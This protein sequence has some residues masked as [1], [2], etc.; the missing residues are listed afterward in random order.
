MSSKNIFADQKKESMLGLRNSS[1]TYHK[2]KKIIGNVYRSYFLIKKYSL[3]ESQVYNNC[4][5]LSMTHA[6]L[7]VC[8]SLA[9][10]TCTQYNRP[11]IPLTKQGYAPLIVDE[12][13]FEW[14]FVTYTTQCS[15]DC[16]PMHTMRKMGRC[17][18]MQFFNW[19]AVFLTGSSQILMF[20]P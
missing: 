10:I 6:Y 12:H 14:C 2:N 3:E 5:K 7:Y 15:K 17:T 16:G 18:G 11:W 1:H 9:C 4:I 13:N 20:V 8:A 19:H